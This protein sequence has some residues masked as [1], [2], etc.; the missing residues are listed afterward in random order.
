VESE[1]FIDPWGAVLVEDYRKIIECFGL[2]PFTDEHLKLLPEPNRLMR[3][4]VVF[5][6]RDLEVILD[7]IR[8]GR[9]FYALT[10]IVPSAEKIHFGNKMVVE[11]MAY[12]QRY[13]DRVYMLVADIE[14]ATVRGIS[15]EESRRRA[16]EF[17]IPAY[18]ALGLDPRKVTFY[19]QSE[20]KSVMRLAHLLS[21]KVT[22][23]ELRAIYGEL[24]P[25]K[26]VAALMDAGDILY[27]QLEE[28]T[29]GI[30]PVGIDQDPHIRLA[31]DLAKRFR[32]EYGF[33]P[34]SSIYHRYTP[35][36][37]GRLKM[38]KSE[39][40]SYIEIPEPPESVREKIWDAFT[41]GR[42]TAREQRELG[43]RPEVCVVFELFKQHLI[44]DDRELDRIYDACKSGEIICGD[45]K[46]LATELMTKFMEEFQ[47]KLERARDVIPSLSFTTG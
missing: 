2:K 4:R 32:R 10:G 40:G 5:C 36:L 16:L 19:F 9:P 14:A 8:N 29:P 23:S 35:S 12:F 25:G 15:L 42:P 34:P 37:D 6:H 47:E 27:P 44:E 41:G 21:A 28:P 11:N 46:T 13:A 24:T 30:I 3:R 33:I 43:G 39:P 20:N 45:C 18:I 1:M 26:M 17:H 22:L 7:A 38:S 31:R